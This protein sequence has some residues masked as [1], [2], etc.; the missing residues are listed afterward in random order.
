MHVRLLSSV[1]V[2]EA[3]LHLIEKSHCV[4]TAPAH[5][6]VQKIVI[7][8]DCSV[9]LLSRKQEGNGLRTLQLNSQTLYKPLEV[10][11]YLH[12]K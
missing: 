1:A 4:L 6:G 9:S 5:L 7:L 12:M 11:T 10:G 2:E 8:G 3:L